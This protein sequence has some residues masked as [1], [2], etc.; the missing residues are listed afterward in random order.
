MTNCQKIDISSHVNRAIIAEGKY[1]EAEIIEKISP[2]AWRHVNLRGNFKF[3][4][5][6]Y[7]DLEKIINE[8]LKKTPSEYA[9]DNEEYFN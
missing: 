6:Q 8:L 7:I 4:H 9:T 1:K 3:K 2:V 5:S